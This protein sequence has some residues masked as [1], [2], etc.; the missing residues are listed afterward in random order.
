MSEQNQVVVFRGDMTKMQPEFAKALPAH[1]TADKF[2]R[3]V[4]T[5]VQNQPDLMQAERQSVLSSCMKAA[6]DGLIIDGKEAALVTFNT[7]N[8][9]GKW[10]KKAQ[11]IPM[12]AGIMK[13]V[14]NSGQLSSLTAQVV[15]KN[16]SFSY[17]PAS[18]SV[19]NHQPDWFGNRGDAIGVYAVAKLKDG[20]N[21]VEIMS[22][23]EV[24]AIRKRSRSG[25]SG[26]WVTDWSEMAR[27]TVIRRI[28]KYL[29]KSSDRPDEER[30]FSAIE[31]ED[32]DFDMTTAQPTKQ[33]N[34][35]KRKSAA[36]ILSGD[37][38]TIDS[39][40]GEL[41]DANGPVTKPME[42]DVM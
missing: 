22:S 41:I 1:I 7:K 42:G 10:E 26:P 13:L 28:S 37:T 11:Y 3:T 5:A 21:V 15:H 33:E 19:P 4:L 8:K 24:N 27:K 20:S 35:E 14:R 38:V 25:E 9:D 2:V 18:D 17:N 34:E 29:P 23:D 12:T 36:E 40:T 32:D 6:S 39:D 30:L 31:R 16:D